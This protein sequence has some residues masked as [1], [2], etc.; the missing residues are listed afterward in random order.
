MGI[1]FVGEYPKLVEIHALLIIRKLPSIPS[2]V[3]FM[4]QCGLSVLRVNV[5]ITTS[6]NTVH[7]IAWHFLAS[8]T[9]HVS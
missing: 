5:R 8:A 3:L 4:C 7:H 1:V 6:Y 9:H 2:V